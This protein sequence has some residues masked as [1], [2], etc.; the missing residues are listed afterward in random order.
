[1]TTRQRVLIIDDEVNMRHML[2]TMLGKLEYH[3][4]VAENGKQALALMERNDFQFALCDIK[5]PEM[6]GLEF[7][8]HAK[9][10][11]PETTV[12]MMSAFGSV[13]QAIEAIRLGAYDYISK[14]FKAD[15]IELTLKK[16]VEREA[17][18]RDNRNLRAQLASLEGEYQFGKMIG[19]S[20]VMQDVFS[21][22]SKVAPYDTTVLITGKSGTGKELIARAIHENSNRHDKKCVAVNCGAFPENLIESELFGYVKGAF[23]GADKDKKGVFQEADGG[24]LF[25]DEIGE[26]PLALQVKLLRVLQEGEVQAVGSGRSHK[27]DVRIVAATARD[28]EQEVAVGR[29]RQDLFYRLDVLHITLPPLS[30]RREDIPLLSNFFLQRYAARLNRSITEISSPA[31]TML[32]EYD[33]PGNVRQ[34]EN[35]IERGVVLADKKIILPENLPMEFGVENQGRRLD[36]IFG[37]FSIKKGQKIMEAKLI[38]R[39]LQV[40]KNNK[41]KA[42]ALLEIS[43]PSLLAKIKEY[44]ILSELNC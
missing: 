41:S 18:L 15:E 2:S 10:A 1:M 34:L 8:A 16:A 12:I 25:L 36:D 20:K 5:M 17:L 11:F 33:W 29:F 37:G 30:E 26:L 21:L 27:V 42:A 28:L 7:L 39:A 38:S 23:T 13:E 4:E 44:R 35:V 19:K 6:N 24:T 22:V 31:M 32:L 9:A 43:Y 40:T 3:A 14:P